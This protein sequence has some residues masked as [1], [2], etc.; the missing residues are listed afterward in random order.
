MAVEIRGTCERR[1]ERVRDGFAAAFERGEELGASV[2]VTVEGETVVDLSGGWADARRSRPWQ[3][4]TLVNVYS[5]TKGMAAVCALV[6]WTPAS[7]TSTRRSRITGPSSPR[8]ERGR[9][10]SGIF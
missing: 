5:T 1:L 7:W 6:W 10:R 9:S 8:R 4:D 3:R 2:C